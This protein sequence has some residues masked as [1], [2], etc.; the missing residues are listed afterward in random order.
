MR[1]LSELS[2]RDILALAISSEEEDAH[3]YADFAVILRPD[4]P[5]SAEIFAN[6]AAEENEH[7][8]RLIALHR[9][10]FGEHIHLVRRQD[11][12][13]F[14]PRRTGW[15]LGPVQP[16]AMRTHA[17]MM[18]MENGR[19]YQLAATRTTDASIRLLLGDLAAAEM[20]H[21]HVADR[22]TQ[23]ALSHGVRESENETARRSFLLRVVQPGL[24][25]LMDGSVSTLAPVFAAAFAT[26][27]PWPTFLVGWR[28]R[29]GRAYP[30]ASRKRC[31]TMAA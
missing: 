7:R 30:W 20:E 13:G 2:E 15:T 19:F 31:P 14:S 27:H 26:H 17:A 16:E 8:Q 24:V 12:R 5:A 4:Y 22:L 6:M 11:V 1:N 18:E 28:R 10:K 25:G 3:V 29:S 9:E 21:G 23:R